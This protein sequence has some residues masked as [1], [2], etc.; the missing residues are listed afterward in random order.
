MI[1]WQAASAS[2]GYIAGTLIQ[3]LITLNNPTYQSQGWQGTLLFW[4]VILLAVSANTVVVSALPKI[5]SLILI[6]HILGFFAIL[7][8]L[9]YLAKPVPAKEVFTIFLN[10]GEWATQGLSFFIG[11]AGLA[12]SF[13]GMY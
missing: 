8:P 6:I 13:L 1:G 2:V 12:F 9:V 7:I 4:A 10:E 5:E 3:G 11:L